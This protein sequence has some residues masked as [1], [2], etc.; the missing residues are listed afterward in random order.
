VVI[1]KKLSFLVLIVAWIAVLLV[2]VFAM[3]AWG[4]TR[5]RNVA[6]IVTAAEIDQQF[7]WAYQAMAKTKPWICTSVVPFRIDGYFQQAYRDLG[8]AKPFIVTSNFSSDL[9]RYFDK[10]YM[11]INGGM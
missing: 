3:K 8:R 2:M 6:T 1:A 9:D 4:A 7:Q 11:A 10:L 5:Q